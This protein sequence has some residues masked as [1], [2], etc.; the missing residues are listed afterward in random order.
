VEPSLE[1]TASGRPN[2]RTTRWGLVAAASAER[3]AEAR[4]AMEQL[5]RLYCYPVYAFI[6][7][8]GYGRQD[9][10]DLTQD[11]FVHLLEKGILGQ[12]D[13]LRGR[14]RNFLLG[15]LKHFLAHAA[16][17]AGAG[18]RGGGCQWVYL[19]DD[20]AED[21]DQL[22][23]P[24]GITAEKLFEA[25]SADALIEATFARLRCELE[26]EGKGHLSKR[27]KF[28]YSAEKRLLT[29]KSPTP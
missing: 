9:A 23:A 5:Y 3:A 20:A 2:F 18:K 21:R 1:S 13:P 6:R 4:A 19:D 25:E 29:G 22:A 10:Q 7:R 11:F 27:S 14:F 15:S 8:R 16:E 26:S 12:A 24:D 28:S 17:R